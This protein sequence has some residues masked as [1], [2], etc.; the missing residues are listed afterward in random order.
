VISDQEHV[1]AFKIIISYSA[2]I[3][4]LTQSQQVLFVQSYR[5]NYNVHALC[6]QWSFFVNVSSWAG[7]VYMEQTM[8]GCIISTLH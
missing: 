4:A 5:Q 6:S 7:V 1:F 8:Q 2:N 3:N